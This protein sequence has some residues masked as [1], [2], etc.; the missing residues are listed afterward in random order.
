[1]PNILFCLGAPDP[2][3]ALIQKFL[4]QSGIPFCQTYSFLPKQEQS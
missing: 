4:E 1:M 2:E 3:M